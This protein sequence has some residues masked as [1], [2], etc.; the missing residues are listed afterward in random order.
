ME[1]E[2]ELSETTKQ[3]PWPGWL[4]C[5]GWAVLIAAFLAVLGVFWNRSKTANKLQQ[6]LAELDRSDPGWRLEVIE[7]A[8]EDVP[9]EENSARVVVAAAQRLPRPWPSFGFPE[10]HFHNLQS[11]ELLSGEDFARLS[12]ELTSAQTALGLTARL[13]D[14]PRGR[15][16]IQYERNPIATLLPH[17][18]E[19][20][21]LVMLLDYESMRRNQKDESNK[22]LT[23]CRTALNVARS[24]GDEPFYISQLVRT[25]CVQ[26]VCRDI[27]RTLGHGEPSP[28]DMSALQKMLESEDA[29]LALLA[30]LRGERAMMHTAFQGVAR[31]E[32]S[33]N[34]L[35]GWRQGGSASD[36]L[37]NTLI[38]LWRMNTPEDHALYLSLMAARIKE[39]QRPMHEQAAMEKEFEAKVRELPKNAVITRLLLP[40]VS[41]MGEA[42]RRKHALLRSTIVALAA[43]RY[44]RE[45]KSWPD[46]LDQLCPPFLSH[47]QLDPYDGKPLRYR[48][49]KDGVLIYSAGQDAVENDGNLDRGHSTLR[50]VD[51]GIRLWDT[52]RRRQP[53]KPKGP[54]QERG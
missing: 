29:F 12:G 39:A 48:R 34:E 19:S 37:K 31:G 36:S 13:A 51:I 5:L 15:H 30:A 10:E 52:A 23:A 2:T 17:V 1:T 9:E 7:A 16:R 44:R 6:T 42:F 11:N 26:H 46:N 8:R 24:I 14:M 20:R 53:P 25:A 38:D 47:V 50:G 3:Q 4:K 27:E 18:Q 21:N 54:M 49:L 43:E 40:A 22:A 28:E 33:V 32:L 41:K 35:G 45:K